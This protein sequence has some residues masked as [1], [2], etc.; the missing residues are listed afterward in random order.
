MRCRC[1]RERERRAD[2]IEFQRADVDRAWYAGTVIEVDTVRRTRVLGRVWASQACGGGPAGAGA[3]N[4]AGEPCRAGA[5][6]ELHRELQQLFMH[7]ATAATLNFRRG[8]SLPGTQSRSMERTRTR[9]R[10]TVRAV[11]ASSTT[12]PVRAGALI[13]SRSSERVARAWRE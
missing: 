2:V 11:G 4:P 7:D 5:M 12:A 1:T 10:S 3:G 9:R 8:T 13:T 6:R